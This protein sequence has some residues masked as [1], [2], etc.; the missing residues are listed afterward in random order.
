M[1]ESYASVLATLVKFTEEKNPTAKG[2]LKYFNSYK[3]ALVTALI[4][5]VHT[6]LSVL[7]CKLQSENLMFS[8]IRPLV[9][10]TLAKLESMKIKDGPCLSEMK[11]RIKIENGTAELSDEKMAFTQSMDKEVESIRSGYLHKMEKNIRD[12]FKKNDTGIFDDLSKILE[13]M[14]VTS[15][16]ASDCDEAIEHLVHFMDMRK[17]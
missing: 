16:T 13:P 14:T 11:G 6:E 3:V 7:S 4:M 10:G 9:H 1:Y 2:L 5:D 8:E 15:S 12:R 17:R